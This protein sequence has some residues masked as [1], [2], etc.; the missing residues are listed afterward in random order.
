MNPGIKKLKD[1]KDNLLFI[2]C[3]EFRILEGVANGTKHFNSDGND[4]KSTRLQ[5]GFA[6]IIGI[7]QSHLIV[8]TG[9]DFYFFDYILEKCYQYWKQF[10]MTRI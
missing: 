5:H 7:P 3:K 2:E 10:I 9:N 4:I 1:F 6:T 8:I